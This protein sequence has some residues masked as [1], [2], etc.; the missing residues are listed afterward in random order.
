MN[1]NEIVSQ[2]KLLIFAIGCELEIESK[3]FEA[4]HAAI[5]YIQQHE[6]IVRVNEQITLVED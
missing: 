5:E 4:I 6:Q 3:D 2:L 1:A